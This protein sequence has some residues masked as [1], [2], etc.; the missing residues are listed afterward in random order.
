MTDLA[1][2][3]VDLVR[4]RLEPELPAIGER[5]ADRV[6]GR[7]PVASGELRDSI[8]SRPASGLAVTVFAEVDHARPL[9]TGTRPHQI[10][11][12]RS[13]GFLSDG[14]DFFAAPKRGATKAVVD[15]PGS[16]KHQGWWT[17]APW[18]DWVREEVDRVLR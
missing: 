3:I 1:V 2:A 9:D 13:H 16:T 17:D 18:D 8:G 14:G 5:I 4:S 10:V 15:H 6:R 11:A 12:T 7:A